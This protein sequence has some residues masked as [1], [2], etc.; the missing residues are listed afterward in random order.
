MLTSVL[1]PQPLKQGLLEPGVESTLH[2]AHGLRVRDGAAR[3]KLGCCY[4]K[5]D[6]WMLGGKIIDVYAE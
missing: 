5:K 2:K 3:A 6:I 4:L 1:C